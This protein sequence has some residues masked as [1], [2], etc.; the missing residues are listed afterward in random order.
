MAG[1]ASAFAWWVRHEPA[2]Y[3]EP[4]ACHRCSHRCL[5]PGVSLWLDSLAPHEFAMAAFLV[6]LLNGFA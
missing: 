4:D 2:A 6:I 1:M 5:H 3:P